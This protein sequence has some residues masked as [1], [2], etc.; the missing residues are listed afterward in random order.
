MLLFS[1]QTLSDS[2][3]DLF[4]PTENSRNNTSYLEGVEVSKTE[5]EWNMYLYVTKW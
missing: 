3:T 1:L 4:F 5:G 2:Q